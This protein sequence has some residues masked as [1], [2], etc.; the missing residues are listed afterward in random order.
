VV[1]LAAV[2]LALRN[3]QGM[4]PRAHSLLA[5]FLLLKACSL[6]ESF[7]TSAMKLLSTDEIMAQMT[8]EAALRTMLSMNSTVKKPDLVAQIQEQLGQAATR[9]RRLRR[10]VLLQENGEHVEEDD[11]KDD[12]E[13]GIAEQQGKVAPVVASQLQIG[14]RGATS[15]VATGM[16]NKMLEETAMKLELEE[17]RC[18]N[19]DKKHMSLME[20]LRQDVADFNSQAAGARSR[21]I[22]AQTE[23]GRLEVKIP[24]IRQEREDAKAQCTSEIG[25]LKVQLALV[26]GDIEIMANVLEMTECNASAV[27]LM[28]C[29]H[30]DGAVLLQHATMQPMLEKLK[31]GV[32]HEYLQR[33]LKI[34]YQESLGGQ[35]PIALT[36]EIVNHIRGKLSGRQ[37]RLRR[38]QHE[39]L[40]VVNALNTSDVPAAPEPLDCT[41]TSKCTIGQSPNCQ[42]LRDRFLVIQAEIVDKRDELSE[43]LV[44]LEE[45]CEAADKRYKAQIEGL[46]D[47]LRSEETNLGVATK[48][49]NDAESQSH[50]TAQAH[51]KMATEYQT[52]MA[53]CCT[54][55]NAFKS[56]T[57]ALKKIRGELNTL[58][59]TKLFTTDCEVSD[60]QESEC[61]VSCG[62]GTMRKTRGVIVPAAYGGMPCLPLE[63]EESCNEHKCPIDCVMNEWGGW[64]ACSAEC[65]GGVQERIRAIRVPA[66]FG[67]NPCDNTEETQSCGVAD[68]DADCVL[69]EW[70]KWSGCSKACGSGT[71]RRLREVKTPAVGTGK[72]WDAEDKKRQ[73][74]KPCNAFP[75]KSLLPPD[76][77]VLRCV[78]KVDIIV[79]LDGSGSLRRYGWDQSKLMAEALIENLHGGT[80]NVMASLLLFSGPKTWKA[81][82]KCIGK[83]NVAPDMEND[84][85]IRWVSHFSEDTQAIANAVPPLQ[86]PAASTL[87][88]VALGEAESEIKNGR[89]DVNTVVIVVTDGWPMSQKK[90]RE[91]ARRL[92]KKASIVW[93]PV[94]SSAPLKMIK[95]LA[96]KPEE[97]HILHVQ[98]FRDLDDADVLNSLISDTCPSVN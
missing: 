15:N 85:G 20:G 83:S 81:Y 79:L 9:S 4:A 53:D 41:P 28:Q 61:T 91:A 30:C 42:I 44:K 67:G 98:S 5:A 93:V 52:T 19:Y 58:G 87:T 92:Q 62:G 43:T 36:Q 33:H 13:S 59:G 25:V 73:K 95:E 26:E 16:L 38:H 37:R 60:W 8:P 80:H 23:I 69:G 17:I 56:E 89:E 65:G 27:L 75:C 71:Q 88:S 12:G 78:S 63:M 3:I 31:S 86:W 68:C 50:L 45:D 70:N 21:V 72:C 24:R 48:D 64:S 14:K 47:E 35:Q 39:L 6:C 7:T 97:E 74:F 34:A 76:R 54:N 77:S 49:Q 11:E 46:E 84:C 22:K 82:K 1:T 2:W 90:T 96:S 55:Q 29:S 40:P 66:E 18:N 10:V 94:G 51:D 32:A 57:C